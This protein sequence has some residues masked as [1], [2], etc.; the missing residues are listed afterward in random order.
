MAKAKENLIKIKCD[1][2]KRINYWTHKN[3]R[4][5]ERKIELKKFCNWC[6]KRTA[7]KEAKK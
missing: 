7:H 6:K 3:K 4:K 2:C 5:V 1:E